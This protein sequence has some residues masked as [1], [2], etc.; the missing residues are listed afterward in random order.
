MLA[1]NLNEDLNKI[2]DW[3]FQWKVSFNP[4]LSKQAQEVIFSCKLQKLVYRPLYFNNIAMT[5]STTQKHLG[6]I[7]DVQL[8]FQEHLKNI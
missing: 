4:G 3:A 8:D 2:N 1:Q 5:Q 6:M 7:L